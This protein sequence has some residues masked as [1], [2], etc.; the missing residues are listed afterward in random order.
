MKLP[1]LITKYGASMGRRDDILDMNEP[2]SIRLAEVRIDR[3][4]YDGFGAY[5]GIGQPLYVAEQDGRMCF[6]R[7]DTRL[8]A[9]AKLEIPYQSLKS[10]PKKAWLSLR[11]FADKGTLGA[12]GIQLVQKL[13]ELGY[14]ASK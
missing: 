13:E 5:W 6:I 2:R 9:A 8:Q 12:T 1:Q 11:S 4:G 14:G 10:P 7:A 3:G